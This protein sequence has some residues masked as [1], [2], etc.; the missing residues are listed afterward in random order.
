MAL[1]NVTWRKSQVFLISEASAPMK[2]LIVCF[3]CSFC[4]TGPI[5]GRGQGHDEPEFYDLAD[6]FYRA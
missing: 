6:R 3:Y 1:I 2:L 4:S 5:N